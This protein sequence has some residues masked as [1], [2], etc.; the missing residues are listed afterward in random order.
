[1]SLTPYEQ[2][3]RVIKFLDEVGIVGPIVDFMA[4]M[5]CFHD[6]LDT[7][8]DDEG[9]ARTLQILRDRY[10]SIKCI[11]YTK[12][13][14]LSSGSTG[15][16]SDVTLGFRLLSVF[17]EVFECQVMESEYPHHILPMIA[18]SM[19]IKNITYTFVKDKQ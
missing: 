1:M 17:D 19:D 15:S 3:A 16:L 7:L 18:N 2:Q 4:V 8:V 14:M 11:V 10:H 13:K 12:A 5:S 9:D 6:N